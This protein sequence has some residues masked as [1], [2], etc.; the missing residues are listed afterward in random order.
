MAPIAPTTKI[1]AATTSRGLG[2]WRLRVASDPSV[3]VLAGAQ[4]AAPMHRSATASGRSTR[5]A[6]DVANDRRR[7]ARAGSRSRADANAS[8]SW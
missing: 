4:R 6:K 1:S 2:R 7:L 8:G 5:L 3:V